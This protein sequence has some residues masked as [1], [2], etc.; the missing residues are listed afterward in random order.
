[1]RTSATST[2]IMID[3]DGPFTLPQTT[4]R[5]GLTVYSD[6]FHTVQIYQDQA[7]Y[8]EGRGQLRACVRS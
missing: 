7:S 5:A 8:S 3:N 2:T 6:G 1:M 4:S